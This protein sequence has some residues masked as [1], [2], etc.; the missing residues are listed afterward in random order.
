MTTRPQVHLEGDD[1]LRRLA[2]E[3]W[4][5]YAELRRRTGATTAELLG[6]VDRGLLVRRPCPDERRMH[7]QQVWEY[8]RAARPERPEAPPIERTHREVTSLDELRRQREAERQ[9]ELG[10]DGHDP[11]PGAA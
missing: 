11:D 6:W 4:H 3:S 1:R 2:P 10:D 5:D 7:G 8:R 9:L